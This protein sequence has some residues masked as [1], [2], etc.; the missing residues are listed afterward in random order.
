[1]EIYPAVQRLAKLL[2]VDFTYNTNVRCR[3]ILIPPE[4]TIAALI[5]VATKLCQPF[6]DIQRIPEHESDPGLLAIDWKEW[7]KIM[8]ETELEGLRRGEAVGVTDM[9]VLKMTGE[10]MDDYMDW[11]QRTWID[12]REPKSLCLNCL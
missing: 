7:N 11:Y 3:G 12:D 9:D 4:T 8:A 6:D 10:K 2:G 5:I 1:V